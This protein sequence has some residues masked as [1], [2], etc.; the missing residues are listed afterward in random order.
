MPIIQEVHGLIIGNS[1]FCLV[2]KWIVPGGAQANPTLSRGN[3]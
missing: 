2:L 1:G 3:L